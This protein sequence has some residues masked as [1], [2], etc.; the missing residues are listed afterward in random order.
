[1]GGLVNQPAFI[2]TFNNPGSTMVGLIVSL[3]EGIADAFS[4]LSSLANASW[5]S[6]LLLWLYRDIRLR[7]K[8]RPEMESRH[9]CRDYGHWSRI[10]K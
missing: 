4:P 9:W 2:S 6:R 5:H 1:M 3:Y 8:A 10:A 7:R